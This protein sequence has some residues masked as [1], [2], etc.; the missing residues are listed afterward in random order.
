MP[1]LLELH[2]PPHNQHVRREVFTA[3]CKNGISGWW[4]EFH[5][6]C[7]TV[8][9]STLHRAPVTNGQPAKNQEKARRVKTEIL[10]FFRV[11]GMYL[12]IKEY[13]TSFL[14]VIKH[15]DFDVLYSIF[16]Q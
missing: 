12:A 4:E 16:S 15:Q 11:I 7:A 1:Q 9:L 3:F 8:S 5:P 14:T 13:K 10:T 2:P 6:A